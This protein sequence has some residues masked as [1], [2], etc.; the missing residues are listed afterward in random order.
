MRKSILSQDFNE[1]VVGDGYGKSYIDSYHRTGAPDVQR[2]LD[3]V[4]SILEN[5]FKPGKGDMYGVG[6][7]S[8]GDWLSQFGGRNNGCM[9]GYGSAIIKYRTPSKGILIFD[10][11]V[12]KKMY[13]VQY[14]LV[15]QCLQYGIYQ[16]GRVPEFIEILSD[17]LEQTFKNPK[18]SADRALHIWKAYWCD[19]VNYASC[20]VKLDNLPSDL[21]NDYMNC[22]DLEKDLYHNPKV[23]GIAFSGNHDGNVLFIKKE[24]LN[25]VKPL[26]YCVMDY[27][28]SSD[29][30]AFVVP[31]TL[32][33]N[34][35][36]AAGVKNAM[37]DFLAA[38]GVPRGKNTFDEVYVKC[39]QKVGQTNA[40]NYVKQNFTWA[41]N[42][43]NSFTGL[44]VGFDDN[45]V[46]YIFGGVW[47]RGVCTAHYFGTPNNIKRELNSM[48]RTELSDVDEIPI[49]KLG[50]F[51]GDEFAG[52][53][54]GGIF[55]KGIFNGVYKG[56]VFDFDSGATWGPL[57]KREN[58][59]SLIC[60]IKYKG[61]LYKIDDTSPDDYLAKLKA[62]AQAVAKGGTAGV[63]TA[64]SLSEAIIEKLPFKVS[65]F[66]IQNN[67]RGCKTIAQGFALFKKTYPWLFGGTRITWW[68]DPE[69]EVSDTKIQVNTGTLRLGDVWFDK[70]SFMASVKGGN[71]YNKNNVFEGIFKGGN[72][73][74]GNFKGTFK[75]GILYIDDLVWDKNA[76][77][78]SAGQIAFIYKK[79]Q[80]TVPDV[81]LRYTAGKGKIKYDSIEKIVN[82]I[83]SGEYMKDIIAIKKSQFLYKRGLADDPERT[84]LAK[85]SARVFKRNVGITQADIDA[86][87]DTDEWD[88]DDASTTQVASY[89]RSEK[90]LFEADFSELD[91]A[92]A[93]SV[94]NNSAVFN[95]KEFTTRELSPT[96]QDKLYQVFHDTY[97][98]VV[99]AAFERDDFDWRAAGWLFYGNPPDDNNPNGMCGGISVRKQQ[100]NNMYKMTSSFGDFRSVLKG[101]DEFNAR[102]SNDP[103]WSVLT[104][105]ISKM[106]Q[107]HCKNWKTLPGVVVKA[108][109]GMIKK[110]SNGEVKS[111]GINGVLKTQTPA[112]MMDKVFIANT[113]YIKWLIDS[114]EDPANASRLPMPQILLKPLVSVIKGLLL[115]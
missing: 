78:E 73:R 103:C 86:G 14:T 96:E 39:L 92:M 3:M 110:I 69:I 74:E 1:G 90:N 77:W 111:V 100:S 25:M 87:T 44:D 30:R 7:Y 89:K 13:G 82:A 79:Q 19:H 114:I 41:T 9:D 54:T 58:E 60:S 94:V 42:P 36:T 113:T 93:S 63:D 31:W 109:E 33:G 27:T 55:R 68:D 10:Y 83:K 102:H 5:G 88:D 28:K 85:Q 4:K 49:M 97:V 101:F 75:G 70:W 106:I 115:K 99:G 65:G 34:G 50:E 104:P 52:V 6:L 26:Q 11:R 46:D 40:V 61:K 47:T 35:V 64:L 112:G 108:M 105:D 16:R 38:A 51:A 32:V 62:D 107:K 45:K 72:Y 98:K 18:I 76:K 17:D 71:V 2:S 23:L 29:P 48:G 37:K 21:Y 56:G 22:K 95:E 20:I 12:A 57:A 24:K 67:W 43:L 53:M 80:F 81:I 8:T 15:D 59:S 91:Y 66:V 84:I